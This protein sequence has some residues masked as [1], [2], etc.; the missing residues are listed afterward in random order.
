[1][2]RSRKEIQEEYDAIYKAKPD[3]WGTL[4]RSSFMI[5]VLEGICPNPKTVV[6]IG[7]GNGITLANYHSHKP[8]A[9]LYGT[10]LSLEGLRLTAER[11]PGVILTDQDYFAEINKFDLVICLGVAEH[12]EDLPPFLISLKEKVAWNGYCYFEVPHN[13]AYSDGPQTYRRLTTRSKQYE[14]HLPR[15]QWE[16]LLLDSGFKIVKS[17]FGLNPTWE[18]IWVLE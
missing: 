1:M 10:D 3:K 7:C 9:Q 8:D 4:D 16:A 11:V 6:D 14:W 12:V 18:F 15:E 5:N 2:T 13:L 17:L